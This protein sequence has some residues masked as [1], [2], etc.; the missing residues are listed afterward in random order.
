MH[1]VLQ[2]HICAYVGESFLLFDPFKTKI[3]YIIP[4]DLYLHNQVPF[5]HVKLIGVTHT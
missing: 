3:L 5:S 1:I 4:Q 2:I